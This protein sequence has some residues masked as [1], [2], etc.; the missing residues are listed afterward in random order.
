M[1]IKTDRQL[2]KK[3]ALFI[4]TLVQGRNTD[5]TNNNT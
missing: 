5:T 2:E 3:L 1:K 4:K